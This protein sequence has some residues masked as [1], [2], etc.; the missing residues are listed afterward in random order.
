MSRFAQERANK[1][2]TP[3]NR[4]QSSTPTL[5]NNIIIGQIIERAND[6]GM[7]IDFDIKSSEGPFL[8]DGGFPKPQRINQNVI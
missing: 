3:E 8:N 6:D 2:K 1:L 4:E 5:A 7:I